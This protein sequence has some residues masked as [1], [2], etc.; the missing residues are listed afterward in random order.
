MKG[1]GHEKFEAQNLTEANYWTQLFPDLLC[2][3]KDNH[4]YQFKVTQEHNNIRPI[5][6]IGFW[7]PG[8]M[9]MAMS[10]SLHFFLHTERDI[11]KRKENTM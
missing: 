10:S 2:T 4:H 11:S 9:D 6:I 7:S 3:Q 5:P 8:L 1:D